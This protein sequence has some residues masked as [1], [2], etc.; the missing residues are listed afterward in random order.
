MERGLDPAEKTRRKDVVLLFYEMFQ[1][2]AHRSQSAN[3]VSEPQRGGKRLLRF[4]YF[5][6]VRTFHA[7]KSAFF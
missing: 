1:S 3:V 7:V 2:H 4:K 6:N 5:G